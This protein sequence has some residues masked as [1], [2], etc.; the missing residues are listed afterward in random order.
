MAG[1]VITISPLISI[2]KLKRIAETRLAR[3]GMVEFAAATAD[4]RQLRHLRRLRDRIAAD[5][6]LG[7]FYRYPDR[8]GGAATYL[9]VFAAGQRPPVGWWG[10]AK[11]GQ[12]D[13]GDPDGDYWGV[14]EPGTG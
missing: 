14:P 4:G 11:I 6:D 8:P 1:T 9:T 12:Q 3:D 2:A 7:V 10:G 13:E 5:P